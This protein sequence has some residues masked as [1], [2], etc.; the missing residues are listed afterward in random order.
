MVAK[1]LTVTYGLLTPPIE[2]YI[3]RTESTKSTDSKRKAL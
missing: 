2:R 1:K 3:E